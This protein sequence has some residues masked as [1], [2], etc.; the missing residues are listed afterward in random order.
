MIID[1]SSKHLVNTFLTK[2][3]E[4]SDYETGKR[5][6]LEQMSSALSMESG[7]L[8]EFVSYLSETG[9]IMIETIG[10]TFL[11]GHISITSK[12]LDRLKKISGS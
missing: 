6:S 7:E 10:G 1:S 4:L 9:Y 2:L 3:A 11:Y 5:V 8:K 12:G